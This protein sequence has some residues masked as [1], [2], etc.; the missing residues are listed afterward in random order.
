MD[1]MIGPAPADARL[2]PGDEVTFNNR[3]WT[4]RGYGPYFTRSFDDDGK[5]KNPRTAK[6]AD[7]IY[8][9]LY[10]EETKNTCWVP[11]NQWDKITVITEPETIGEI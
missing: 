1:E 2:T 10:C 5:L 9:V 3:T 8:A 11:R 6:F 7:E 4:F